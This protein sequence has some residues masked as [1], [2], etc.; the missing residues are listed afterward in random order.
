M[1]KSLI[2]RFFGKFGFEIHGTGFI[3]SIQKISFKEDPLLRQKEI[4]GSNAR[5]IFD[6]GANRG[7]VALQYKALFPSSVIYAFEPFPE[8]FNILV[9]NI[10]KVN[11]IIAYQ[12]AIANKAQKKNYFL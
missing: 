2:N 10:S 5:I 3:Q 12:K 7:D 8:T 11:N 6:I 4:V 9:S 1:N